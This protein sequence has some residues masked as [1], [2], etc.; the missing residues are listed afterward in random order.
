MKGQDQ[1]K[2]STVQH[3][4]T[5]V[6]IERV[7]RAHEFQQSDGLQ[8][9]TKGWERY[10]KTEPR[11]MVKDSRGRTVIL[12]VNQHMIL[13]H[14]RTRALAIGDI[15]EQNEQL[16]LPDG[17]SENDGSL[18]SM[19][20]IANSLGIAPSTVSRAVVLLVAFRLI[21]VDV[22]RGRYGGLRVL[23]MAWADLKGRARGA[24]ERIR[25]TR[26]KAEVR[27]QMRYDERLS[28]T[29]YWWSGLNVASMTE[30]SATLNAEGA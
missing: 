6:D 20:K 2:E 13:M 23:S 12:T 15:A 1:V 27:A 11:V 22:V 30:E 4:E 21:A 5:M 29:G 25:R 9:M 16:S 17:P 7:R 14:L 8:P 24:W 18:V 3:Y 10:R 26:E 28:R 19:T